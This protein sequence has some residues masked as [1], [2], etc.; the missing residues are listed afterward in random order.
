MIQKSHE[1]TPD[2][3]PPEIVHKD[4]HAVE[5]SATSADTRRRGPSSGQAAEKGPS[6]PVSRKI[7]VAALSVTKRS[8][9]WIDERDLLHIITRYSAAKSLRQTSVRLFGSVSPITHAE[10]FTDCLRHTC[11]DLRRERWRN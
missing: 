5:A 6:V 10:P 8:L 9:G 7:N 4:P 11:G 3:R 1:E 2:C